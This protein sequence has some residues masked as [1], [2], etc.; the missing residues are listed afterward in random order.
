MNPTPK[1]GGRE[2]AFT[3]IEL[4]VV[5][6]IIAI[7]AAMLLPALAKAKTKAQL[8]QCRSNLRQI[9]LGLNMYV[10]DG[11]RFP[12]SAVITFETAGPVDAV[13]LWFHDLEPYV[14][15]YWTNQLWVCPANRVADPPYFESPL[16][17]PLGYGYW[18]GSYAYN[19]GGTDSSWVG[20]REVFRDRLLGLGE[21]GTR[22]SRS[23]TLPALPESAV[24]V[25][26]EMIALGEDWWIMTSPNEFNRRNGYPWFAKHRWHGA[27]A[28]AA[29]VD[30]HVQFD[31]YDALYG[32][33]D[34]ARRRW[35]NDHEPH[36]ETWED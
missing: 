23:T 33:N 29:F 19:A 25:P 18:A 3:V 13:D 1:P 4:L 10:G 15:A 16:P 21:R 24:R 35:N 20:G 9:G 17:A 14:K 5:I 7:L 36:P 32:K 30:G 27:G 2:P 6:A 8:T 26:A 22:N 11:S 34:A 31:K 28:N 12:Y